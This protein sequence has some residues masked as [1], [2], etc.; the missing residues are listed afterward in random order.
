LLILSWVF[1]ALGVAIEVIRWEFVKKI[2]L[3][4][5]VEFSIAKYVEN[6]FSNVQNSDALLSEQ[7]K[8]KTKIIKRMRPL[9]KHDFALRCSQLAAMAIAIILSGIHASINHLERVEAIKAIDF[10]LEQ[11][12]RIQTS[13]TSTI[14]RQK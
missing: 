10:K 3:N 5:R 14:S 6:Q 7:Q 4:D 11:V 9:N 2:Q 8:L 13:E 12:Q 1:F